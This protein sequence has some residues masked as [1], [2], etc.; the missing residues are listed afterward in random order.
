[1]AGANLKEFTD[2]NFD[3]EVVKSKEPVLVDFW[4]P[5]C[6]P[7]RVVAP[8]VEELATEYAGRVKVGK[9]NTDENQ[10][11]SSRYGIMSIPSLLVFRDGKVAEQIIG[12]VPKTKIKA[13]IESVVNKK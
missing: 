8:S 6:G 1:M 5:W 11:T 10:I 12:A 7:C 9:L 4:A 13:A 3:T 2:D